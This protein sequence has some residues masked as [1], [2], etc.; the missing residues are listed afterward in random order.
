MTHVVVDLD[1]GRATAAPG[2]SAAAPSRA[3]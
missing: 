1:A 3:A 2:S